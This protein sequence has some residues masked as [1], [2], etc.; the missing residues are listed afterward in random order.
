LLKKETAIA[1]Q[2]AIKLTNFFYNKGRNHCRVGIALPRISL[3]PNPMNIKRWLPRIS[4]PWI[5]SILGLLFALDIVSFFWVE[6]QWFAEVGYSTVFWKKLGTQA[7]ASALAFGLSLTFLGIHWLIAR[8]HAWP[9]HLPD[10]PRLPGHMG[11]SGLLLLVLLCSLLISGL[12]VY[13][14]QLS[15]EAWQ[16]RIESPP[17]LRLGVV[18]Q[19]LTTWGLP[20]WGIIGGLTIAILLRSQLVLG[21]IALLIS[22]SYGQVMADHWA[23][24]L[25]AT[26]S[27]AFGQADPLLQHDLSFYI[28]HLP[29]WELVEYGVISLLALTFLSVVVI[30]L[31]SGDSLS[32]GNFPGFT[33]PQKRHLY[34]LAATGLGSIALVYWFNRYRLLYNPDGVVFGAGY[35]HA[36]IQ[37]PAYNL[38]MGLALL[39]AIGLLLVGLLQREAIAIPPIRQVF[40]LKNQV[41]PHQ[42]NPKASSSHR[43]ALP[44]WGIGLFIALSLAAEWLLPALIQRA[45]VQPNELQLEQPFIRHGI[46]FTRR[47]FNLENIDVET[48]DPGNSL[49]LADVQNNRQTVD[50]IRLW[51]TRPLL[52]TNR[53]LQRIRLYYEFFGADIDRYT[54]PTATNP[55]AQQQVLIAARELDYSAVPAAAQTWVNKHLI[56]THGYGFTLSPVNTAGEGG[57]PDYLVQGLEPLVIDPRL[58]NVLP[59]D[60]P[61]IYYGEMTDTYVMTSTRVKELDYPS[62]SENV[63]NTYDGRGGVS[64]GQFWQRL[65]LAKYLRDWRMLLTEDFTPQT[66]VLF[67]RNINQRVRA[68]APFLKYDSNP[69]LVVADPGYSDATNSET[70][71]KSYL[72]WIIDAY[73]TSDRYPYADPLNHSFNYIR[74][75]VKVVIDAYHGSVNFYVADVQD[76]IIQTWQKLFPKLFQPLD[77]MPAALRQHIRYPQDLYRVQSDHLM[78]YHMT[79]PIVFYNRE[80]QWRAPN[81]IYGTKQQVVEPYYLITKLPS[82]DREEFILLRPFTPAQRNNLIAWLSARSDGD[83]YGKMLLYNFPK[84]RLIY[85]PEQIEARINQDPIISQQ[86][87]LW[88]RQ[89]SRAIQGNLLV[90]PIEQSLLYVEP[91]YLEAEQNQ[92]PTLVK[93]IVAYRD[94]IVMADTLP[95]AI[96]TIFRPAPNSQA[97]GSQDKALLNSSRLP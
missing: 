76:P 9:Q 79:D 83:Q 72:Y 70:Q 52:E 43:T 27:T 63:Y 32:Q 17:P 97:P 95:E 53:Q 35:T 88:N 22:L 85:G 7:I 23:T 48:F 40:K 56:Y 58:K 45:V 77:Q 31:T 44:L 47:A 55:E 29:V 86:I 68:I 62:G 26:A 67:R 59:I 18:W 93:V 39:T 49:T 36:A 11:L 69:Y 74:N 25:A 82:G 38:L 46:A 14:G 51:D 10:R 90:I 87:S 94:R 41:N 66:R 71:S 80:D 34:S 12:L 16:T 2:L 37:L 81:E 24:L 84:Q 8:R 33:P 96:A 3:S 15:L 42:V 19:S 64:I 57:L 13:Q 73:T 30:Y 6:A 92:L 21:A 1:P 91:L 65:I 61:R 75:S 28:F 78:T 5:L 54:I 20:T 50:N 60:K 89:G 4:L